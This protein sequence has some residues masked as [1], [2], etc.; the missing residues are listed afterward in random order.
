MARAVRIPRIRKGQGAWPIPRAE[1][2]QRFLKRF[3]DPRF[4]G[5]Q[6][7]E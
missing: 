6:F 3:F 7:D 1:F 5:A 2:E 4:G